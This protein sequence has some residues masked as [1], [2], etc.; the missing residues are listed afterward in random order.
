[1]SDAPTAIAY[2][3]LRA[4]VIP[5]EGNLAGTLKCRRHFVREHFE[6]VFF[7]DKSGTTSQGECETHRRRK[8]AAAPSPLVYRQEVGFKP[9]AVQ[10]IMQ[11][12]MGAA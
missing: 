11:Q 12:L 4:S 2:S 5:T 8:G 6:H 9:P 1:M 10:P 3:A 7:G